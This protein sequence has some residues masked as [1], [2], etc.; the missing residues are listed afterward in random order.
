MKLK[1]IFDK[2]LIKQSARAGLLLV[3]VAALT[4]EATS[5]IQYFYAR[6]GLKEECTRRAESELEATKFQIMDIINQA[7]SAVRNS[8]WIAAWSLDYP[9]SMSAVT[10]RVVEQNEV[11][12]GSALAL[13]PG[14]MKDH[15]L[16]C[17][18]AYEAGNGLQLFSLATPEYDYPSK[19]W[20]TKPVEQGSGYWSEP[21]LD[22]G[23]GGLLMTTYSLPITD[24]SGKIAAVLTADISLDWLTSLVED[25]EVFPEAFS[26]MISRQGEIMVCP[27][28]TLVMRS[29]V[30]EASSLVEDTTINRLNR[31]MLAGESGSMPIRF[32]GKVN[33]VF[34]APVERTGWSMSIVVPETE[35]YG[36]LSRMSLLVTLLQILGLA[37]L[38]LILRSV[39]KNSLKYKELNDRKERIENELRI[40]RGIQMSMVPK[41]FPPFPERHDIDISAT[42]HPAKEVGGDLYDF[43]IRDEKLFFC[44]GDV[45]GKG[46]PASL[47]M[48]VTRSL[49]RTVS[50]HENGPKRIVTSMNESMADMNENNMFVTFFCG[51]LELSSGHL[52]YCNAG[53]N[54]P[55]LFANDSIQHLPVVPNLPL[56]II[57]GMEYQEQEIDLDHDDALF[58][59]TDGVT[60]AENVSHELFGEERLQE[61]LSYRRSAQEHLQ[62]V[63]DAVSEFVKEAPQSDDITMLF[64]HYLNANKQSVKQRHLVIHNKIEE[65]SKLAGF[66]EAVAGDA[67]IDSSLALNLNLALEEAVTNVVMYAYTDGADGPVEIDAAVRPGEIVFT[68]SD[69]G[70]AFD[71]T[72]AP[73][74][75]I[76]KSA[77]ERK[78]GGL[79]IHLVRKLM[80]DVTYKRENAKNVLTMTKKI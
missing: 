14:Y 30:A 16:C 62:A 38:V 17:P 36:E 44:I 23:G 8:A 12:M 68:V 55:L 46:I 3:V 4:L 37:M 53:H 26:M 43:H 32:N 20:F 48:A 39:I 80:D 31:S 78:I 59:Y 52:R 54:A 41:I 56:G 28:E 10:R 74:V 65:I 76:T 79:G 1:T 47:V 11:V 15:E 72:A 75:D 57:P 51:T 9:D 60:E 27:A 13:V 77:D 19:E 50:A 6:H 35:I 66:V 45:S 2:R 22:T 24:R 70:K 40:G 64:L 25:I 49:F 7:E 33:H 69:T 5:L 71:P 58:L 67:K 42:L 29:N 61:V 73:E 21:Y 18:Y 34:F 63:S